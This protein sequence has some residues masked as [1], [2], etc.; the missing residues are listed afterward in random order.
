MALI[1]RVQSYQARASMAAKRAREE[2]NSYMGIGVGAV[3]AAGL[4]ALNTYRGTPYLV[5]GITLRTDL[6][7]AAAGIGY[8]LFGGGAKATRDLARDAG[9]S[10]LAIWASGW[11]ATKAAE[12][13]TKH[14]AAST[15]GL[16]RQGMR[17][18]A[19][20]ATAH[21]QDYMR[22]AHMAGR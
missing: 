20:R 11:G 2:A 22:L 3:T 19:M 13:M 21:H 7:V 18:Q 1:D 8:A 16:L 5:E 9:L 14:P 4:G 12:Y 15:S 6:T 17:P 10:A